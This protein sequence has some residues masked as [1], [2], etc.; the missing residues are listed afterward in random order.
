MKIAV[1]HSCQGIALIIV[2]VSILVLATLAGG[3]AYSM[4]IETKLA[5]NA[6][7]ETELEWLGRSG[8]EMARWY[9]AE[10]MK[11]PGPDLNPKWPGVLVGPGI[12]NGPL[13]SIDINAPVEL[14]RGKF[15]ITKITDLESKFNINLADQAILERALM[16]MGAEAGNAAEVVGSILD[17]IDRDE[18]AHV[19]G[20]ES[21]Y[22][23]G[24]NPPYFAKNGPID[25]LSEM[26]LIRGVTP[27]IFWGAA[28]TNHSPAAFQAKA[29]RF[30]ILTQPFSNPV[31]L[32]DLFTPLSTG[33]LNLNTASPE[34]LQLI[35]GVD[36]N[37]AQAIV[38]GRQGGGQAEPGYSP[39]VN[40]LQGPYRSVGDLM[41]VSEIPRPLLGQFQRYCDVRSRTFEIQVE[42]DI[43]GYRRQFIAV[44]GGNNP[45]D[46][47]VLT[48]FWR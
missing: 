8:V 3:F 13:A 48:F 47:Q 44:I 37:M 33:R 14:G 21:A 24:F 31:G 15:T 39:N 10:L 28:C 7:Y 32:V 2:M 11:T 18:M 1:R 40:D 41:R 17:W 23:Q 38:A 35:P 12:T 4:K 19:S 46:V 26:L 34:T 30:G 20:T 25:D 29:S 42:A 43:S 27:E 22:Y 36:N 5:R 16:A 6:N 9:Y 45:R